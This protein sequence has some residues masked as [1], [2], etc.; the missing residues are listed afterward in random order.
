MHTADVY[1]HQIWRKLKD[2]EKDAIKTHLKDSGSIDTKAYTEE[3]QNLV[4][5]EILKK[6]NG[7]Y[8]FLVELFKD[9]LLSYILKR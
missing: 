1:F 7:R 9:W 2:A 3:L 6:E 5:N 4:L 8:S